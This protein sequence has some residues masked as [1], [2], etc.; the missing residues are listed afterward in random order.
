MN[1]RKDLDQCVVLHVIRK[2]YHLAVQPT[3]CWRTARLLERYSELSQLAAE[4][5]AVK[6]FVIYVIVQLRD[7]SHVSTA[8]LCRCFK[9]AATVAALVVIVLLDALQAGHRR[10]G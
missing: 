8:V 7:R 4:A 1:W 3:V 10:M 5:A 6:V 2:P 9:T